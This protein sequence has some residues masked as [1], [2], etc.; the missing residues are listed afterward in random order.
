MALTVLFS[1]QMNSFKLARLAHFPVIAVST[2]KWLAALAVL[3]AAIGFA[4][5]L[6]KSLPVS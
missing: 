4:L 1:S 3:G 5:A 2:W 6:M